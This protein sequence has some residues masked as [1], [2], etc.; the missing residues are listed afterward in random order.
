MGFTIDEM[1]R[2]ATAEFTAFTSADPGLRELRHEAARDPGEILDLW[3][4]LGV[5][6]TRI[7]RLPVRP[8][9]AAKWAL[10]WSFDSSSA[11]LF[12]GILSEPDLRKLDCEIA[13]LPGKYA[14]C[15]AATGLAPEEVAKE[16]RQVRELA[17]LPLARLPED[18]PS[19]EPEYDSVWLACVC[20][21]AAREA[22]IRFEEAMHDLPLACVCALYVSARIREDAHP[23]RIRRRPRPEVQR[24]IDQRYNELCREFLAKPAEDAR[25]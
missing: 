25:R 12:L 9:T 11:D 4:M 10:W 5:C 24:R 14:N 7:G 18:A 3:E 16:I 8:L 2:L 17:F 20:G 19:G 21:I 22:N 6:A 15:S 13:S 23:E 1:R